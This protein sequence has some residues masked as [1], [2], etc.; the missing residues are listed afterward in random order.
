MSIQLLL[1]IHEAGR[2]AVHQAFYLVLNAQKVLLHVL[3]RDQGKGGNFRQWSAVRI[4][5]LK[6]LKPIP[7]TDRKTRPGSTPT[8]RFII[9]IVADT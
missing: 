1:P 5:A 2:L 4:R 9:E 8:R 3:A 6:L 7:P